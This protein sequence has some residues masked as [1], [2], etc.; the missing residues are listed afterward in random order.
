MSEELK[1]VP[2]SLAPAPAPTPRDVMAAFFRQRK[3]FVT[4]FCS[5]LLPGMIYAVFFPSYK[6]EMK[7]LVRRARMDPLPTSAA[8]QLPQFPR[9]E[10]SEDELNS[11]AEILQDDDILRATATASGLADIQPWYRAMLGENREK[12]VAR[13]VKQLARK[14]T[15]EPAKK[16]TVIGVSYASSDPE[17]S[18]RVLSCLARAYLDRHLQVRRPS[19]ESDFFEQQMALARQTM[20]QAE[21]RLIG[22]SRD[23]GVVSADAER[24]S[25][26][27]K[28]SQ[29]EADTQQTRIALAETAQRIR[30]LQTKLTAFP[31]RTTTQTKNADNPQ[32][33]EKIKS[34][35]LDLRLERTELLTKF[36][37]SYRLVRQLDEEIAEAK[38]AIDAEETLPLREQTVELDVNHEWTKAELL[39]AQVEL[40]ALLARSAAAKSVM[41]GYRESALSLGE[42]AIEQQD[43]LQHLKTAEEQYVLYANKREEARIGDALDRRGILNVTL[44]QSPIVPQLPTHSAFVVG[45]F[46]VFLA[47]GVSTGVAFTADYLDPSLRTPDEVAGFLGMPVLASLPSRTL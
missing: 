22:Y 3:L 10:V 19:G 25:T 36:G 1:L 14:I 30:T 44:A 7:V 16:T 42:R 9:D 26:L 33:M 41:A 23:Q 18:A 31:E 32:L 24:D 39:K 43:L 28:L 38:A 2:R 47:G 5:I 45:L 37:S 27:Q 11:E 15:V 34:K 6:A 29:A 35:L 21:T 46:T 13:A 12:Q 4:A 40:N 8:N 17:R 20:E